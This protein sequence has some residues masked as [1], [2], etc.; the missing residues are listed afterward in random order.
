[1]TQDEYLEGIKAQR[2]GAVKNLALFKGGMRYFMNGVDRSAE[3]TAT[4]EKMVADYDKLLGT[5]D[6]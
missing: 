3:H 2:M 1:M 6:A 4:L 5:N